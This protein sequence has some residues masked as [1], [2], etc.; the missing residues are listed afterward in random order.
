MSS[1]TARARSKP[2]KAWPPSSA[3]RAKKSSAIATSSDERDRHR[4]EQRADPDRRAPS[5]GSPATGTVTSTAP[6]Q[7][8]KDSRAPRDVHD[9][10]VSGAERAKGASHGDE[11]QRGRER[12]EAARAERTRD[13]HERAA[14]DRQPPRLGHRQPGGPSAEISNCPHW[15]LAGA[16]PAAE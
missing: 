5:S 2:W 4:Q 13:E 3:T 12:A 11:R 6:Q 1:A 8:A 16:F 7:R 15:H 9:E 14:L 10:K